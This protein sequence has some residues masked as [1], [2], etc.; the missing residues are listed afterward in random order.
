MST[1]EKNELEFE[2]LTDIN[3]DYAR[4]IGLVFTLP[5]ELRP[6]YKSFGI[7]LE[8]HNGKGQ[9]DLSLAATFVVRVDGTITY[10]FVA[11]D[12]TQ[13]AEPADIVKELNGR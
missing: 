5:E 8:A 6:I 10:A 7:E 4:E 11:A 2:V 12:Y 13:R 1:S 3:S 9:F